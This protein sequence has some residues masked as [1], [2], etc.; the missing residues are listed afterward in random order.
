MDMPARTL[1]LVVGVVG[2]ST[3]ALPWVTG[4]GTVLFQVVAGEAWAIVAGVTSGRYADLHHGLVWLVA[5]LLNVGL[6]SVPA[7]AV[8]LVCRRRWPRVAVG[9]VIGWGVLWLL[10]LFIL[11]PATDG[12]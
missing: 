8:F 5:L 11:F 4:Y 10:S 12:P 7:L 9:A 3:T 2:A 6:F 1:A